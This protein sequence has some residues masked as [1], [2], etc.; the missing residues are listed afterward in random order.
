[1]SHIF[2]FERFVNKMSY[3]KVMEVVFYFWWICHG[4]R[5]SL[6]IIEL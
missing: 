2:E 5:M 4:K 6:D 3:L 1:M